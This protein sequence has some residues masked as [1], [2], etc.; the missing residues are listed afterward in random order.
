MVRVVIIGEDDGELF[1]ISHG[2]GFAVSG[3][4]VVTNAH[5]VRDALR[6]EGM[7]IGIVPNGG[8]EAVYGRIVA[9]LAR[10]DLALPS[11]SPA[12]CA[13]PPG[14]GRRPRPTAARSPA[15]AIR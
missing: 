14:A 7:Q 12:S 8:G 9:V 15:S 11:A 2:T 3:D 4:T 6:D 1:P 5:V 10:N 13:C